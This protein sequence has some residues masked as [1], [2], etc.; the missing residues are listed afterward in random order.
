MPVAMTSVVMKSL[1]RLVLSYLK[2][3]T[4][5]LLDPLEFAYRANM[6]A[7]VAVNLELHYIL[8]NFDSKDIC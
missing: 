2:D 4:G 6:L 1:E 8:Q 7:D 3:I 5:S